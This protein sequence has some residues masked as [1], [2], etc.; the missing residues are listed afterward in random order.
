M[1]VLASKE[2]NE[3]AAVTKELLFKFYYKFRELK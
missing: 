3:A 2:I 1:R